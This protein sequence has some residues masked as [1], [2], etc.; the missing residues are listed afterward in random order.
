MR[1]NKMKKIFVYL[2][3]VILL[4]SI[5]SA[6][7]YQWNFTDASSDGFADMT[8]EGGNDAMWYSSDNAHAYESYYG[9]FAYHNISESFYNKFPIN[10][11][12]AWV[13]VGGN[14]LRIGI[15]HDLYL[16]TPDSADLTAYF[17]G[18]GNVY[19]TSKDN[20]L[21]SSESVTFNDN[22]IVGF[23]LKNANEIE[24][25][26]NGILI[27]NYS[28]ETPL[29]NSS[30][31][32][33]FIASRIPETIL[34]NVTFEFADEISPSCENNI[35]FIIG[36][37]QNITC[38]ITN[39]M[40]ESQEIIMYDANDCGNVTN[41][42]SYNY[43]SN[44][45]SCDFCT[46]DWS[47]N[48]YDS[49]MVNDTQNCNAVEDL[50]TC[51]DVYGGD[52]SEF[53]PAGCNYCTLNSSVHVTG[54][55]INL[56]TTYYTNNN[57]GS[58]CALTGISADCDLPANV[59]TSCLVVPPITGYVPAHSS[60][61]VPAVVVDLGVEFGLQMIALVGIVAL[62]GLGVY[63]FKTFKKR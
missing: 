31:D 52:Y 35:S 6:T 63:V 29:I 1:G 26:Q 54:C 51:G 45:T 23:V 33:I 47:C 3:S 37:W 14:Q 61:D 49:C 55:V 38:L 18:G 21:Y 28:S 27:G 40:N 10:L 2:L 17:H 8:L 56:N 46:P 42:T 43:R 41:S 53:T 20:Y 13:S 4:L 58:C 11:S 9:A 59:T 30:D 50:N 62:V 60:S 22:D 39:Y 57:Y 5:V 7:K 32:R 25:Y 19:F 16:L 44:T 48:G 34:D 15:T 36:S 24:F 12:Y